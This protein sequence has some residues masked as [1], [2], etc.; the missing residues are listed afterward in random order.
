VAEHHA[1]VLLAQAQRLDR[2]ARAGEVAVEDDERP[3]VVA[4]ADV[5]VVAQGRH[6]CAAQVAHP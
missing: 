3:R 5:I 4:A 6:R 2:A 1:R